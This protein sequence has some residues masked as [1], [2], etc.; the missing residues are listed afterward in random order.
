MRM[1]QKDTMMQV[2]LKAD[3]SEIEFRDTIEINSSNEEETIWVKI[4]ASNKVNTG[5]P[6]EEK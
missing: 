6:N 1:M 4:D 3:S 2:I 5:F